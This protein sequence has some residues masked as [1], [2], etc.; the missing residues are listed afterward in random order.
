MTNLY[1]PIVI[2]GVEDNLTST[3]TTDALSA[4]MGRALNAAKVQHVSSRV[5]MKL[6]D[7]VTYPLVYLWEGKRS[8]P[9]KWD[10]SIPIATHQADSLE[11]HMVATNSGADGAYKRIANY[12]HPS[13]GGIEMDTLTDHSQEFRDLFNLA[14]TISLPI[15]VDGYLK[16]TEVL[17]DMADGHGDIHGISIIGDNSVTFVRRA[18]SSFTM[19]YNVGLTGSDYCHVE[20]INCRYED[21]LEAVIAVTAGQTVLNYANTAS[22]VNDF[23]IFYDDTS[24]YTNISPT[25]ITSFDS[26]S[27]TFAGGT[28][29]SNGNVAISEIDA[30]A[31]AAAIYGAGGA[32]ASEADY[33][34][35]FTIKNCVVEGMF[36]V[37]IGAQYANHVN[38]FDCIVRGIV[39]RGIYSAFGGNYHTVKNCTIDG[40]SSA[41]TAIGVNLTTYGYNDNPSVNPTRDL[42][43]DGCRFENCRTRGGNFNTE[44]ARKKITNS[45]FSNNGYSGTSYD[46]LVSKLGLNNARIELSNLITDSPDV[47]NSILAQGSNV[48]IH[49]LDLRGGVVTLFVQGSGTPADNIVI[50]NV[51]ASGGT[52]QS[53]QMFNVTNGVATGIVVSGSPRLFYVQNCPDVKL[54]IHGYGQLASGPLANYVQGSDRASGKIKLIDCLSTWS[55]Q[56][57]SSEE[58]Y[59]D[60]YMQ[61]GVNGLQYDG[62]SPNKLVTGFISNMSGV[63][64]QDLST[65][66][67]DSTGV[68]TI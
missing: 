5:D 45:S 30:S 24:G 44:G 48:F 10:A 9:F 18:L 65:A 21:Q 37:G 33:I 22:S 60:W 55:C 23:I 61:G 16:G 27:V 29:P 39:N 42:L 52:T 49:D 67:T 25:A 34:N 63:D 41:G 53:F 11:A 59:I 20:G 46:F 32:A 36:Y 3:S 14:R 7:P 40:A 47:T 43:I 12:I 13:H 6:L 17:M 57:L 15:R 4:N 51:R 50:N 1:D 38:V 68:H 8:G 35:H 28:F 19:F 66:N 2:P 62:S 56:V 26:T 54:D 64:F 31:N 58:T